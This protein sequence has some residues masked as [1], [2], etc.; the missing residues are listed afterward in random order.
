MKK[1][2]IFNERKII[3]KIYK[4]TCPRESGGREGGRGW[5]EEREKERGEGGICINV[6]V[7]KRMP[8]P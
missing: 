3:I 8:P 4:S 7:W 1:G 6:V 2:S 5:R